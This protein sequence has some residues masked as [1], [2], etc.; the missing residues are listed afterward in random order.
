MPE[1]ASTEKLFIY[2]IIFQYISIVW[3]YAYFCIYNSEKCTK[4][5]YLSI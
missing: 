3:D 5:K 4:E 1:Q 2:R